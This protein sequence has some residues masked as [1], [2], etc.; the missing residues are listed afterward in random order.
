M[1]K[2]RL[3]RINV[4]ESYLNLITLWAG[5]SLACPLFFLSTARAEHLFNADGDPSQGANY[6]DFRLSAAQDMIGLFDADSREIDRVLF[7][8]QTTDVSQGRSPD[9]AS[10]Y[11]YF[12]FPTP[13]LPNENILSPET[14]RLLDFDAA[15]NVELSQRQTIIPMTRYRP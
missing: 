6:L 10:D 7:V 13:G 12:R 1:T 14:T 2:T 11:A 9:A 3:Q 5:M 4:V 8:S 15:W